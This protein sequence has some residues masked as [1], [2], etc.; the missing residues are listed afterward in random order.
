[1]ES[2]KSTSILN[3]CLG[4]HPPSDTKMELEVETATWHFE[5]L[6]PGRQQANKG[7]SVLGWGVIDHDY[8]SRGN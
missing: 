7:L 1:M 6:E 8:L 3:L 5:L 4:F 2:L